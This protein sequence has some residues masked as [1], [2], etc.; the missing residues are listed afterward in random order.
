MSKV[1]E[2]RVGITR[3][4]LTL[5]SVTQGG[6]HP[7]GE[8][9]CACGNTTVTVIDRWWGEKAKSCGCLRREVT[10]ARNKTHG[11]SRT[12][13]YRIW[14]GMLSRCYNSR[15]S[16]YKDYGAKGVTVG[17]V[18]RGSF[19]CFLRDMGL[20][21]SAAYSI[22][23]KDHLKGYFA[24]NCYW[25]TDIEQAR[26]K[27]TTIRYSYLGQTK[28]LKEFADDLGLDY[29]CVYYRHQQG[30]AVDRLFQPSGGKS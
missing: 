15:Y 19:E 1:L 5:R 26:N 21:P 24:A 30:W 20:R 23:R 12:A 17:E 14:T 18:W 9:L 27:S 11:K 22:E 7:R 29:H 3:G 6:K 28:T 10:A 8:F 4:R 2:S 25:A 16:G 13:E